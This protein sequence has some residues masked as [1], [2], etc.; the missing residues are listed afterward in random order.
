MALS[1]HG[2]V[3]PVPSDLSGNFI[4]MFVQRDRPC[5]LN[6]GDASND[7]IGAAKFAEA[8]VRN[9]VFGHLLS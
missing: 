6:F 8:F 3:L 7:Q 1:S 9:D 2:E 4:K 5:V